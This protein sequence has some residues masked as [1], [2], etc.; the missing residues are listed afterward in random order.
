MSEAIKSMSFLD[1][2]DAHSISESLD[3]CSD[4]LLPEAPKMSITEME[5]VCLQTNTRF[6]VLDMDNTNIIVDS[7]SPNIVTYDRSSNHFSL[8]TASAPDVPSPMGDSL[9]S[10][11]WNCN[12][13]DVHK[14]IKISN[15]AFTSKADAILITDTRI[16]VW[17]TKAAVDS[18]SKSLQKAT[19]KIWTGFASPKHMEH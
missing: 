6:Q 11:N 8:N 10:I 16:D 17:R 14:S 2:H 15:L 12:S 1:A 3:I 7:A 5:A 19:G 13:W 4:G 9:I 18:F